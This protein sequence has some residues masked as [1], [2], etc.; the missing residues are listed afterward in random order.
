[1]RARP[2]PPPAPPMTEDMTR[3]TGI[4]A[5][6]SEHRNS[7]ADACAMQAGEIAVLKAQ[8]E[9][10]RAERD[11]ARAEVERLTAAHIVD[12]EADLD[13]GEPTA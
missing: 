9:A 7:L 2:T 10:A 5:T 4:M 12:P 6:L 8:L 13:V 1:M 3:A 11:A